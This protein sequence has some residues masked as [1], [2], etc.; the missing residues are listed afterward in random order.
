MK[1]VI[2][3]QA[4]MSSTRLPGKVLMDLGGRPMLSQQLRRLGRCQRFDEIVVATTVN[5]T[6]DPIVAMAESEGVRWFR[7]SEQDVLSRYIG[8]AREAKADIVV[9]VTA[10]CPLIDP[11]ETDK[12]IREIELHPG[13]CDYAANVVHR[14]YP[15]GLDTEAMFCDALE[16]IGRLGRSLEAQ[17]HVTHFLRKERSDLF[18]VRSVTDSE[19]NSHLRWTV[20]TPEDMVMVRRLC[21]T[22]ALGDRYLGYREMLAQ[23]R[24]HPELSAVNAGV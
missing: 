13:E 21:E 24:A 8:A 2:I 20:D 5:H 3:V 11:E 17:E 7:G 23:I 10:D 14:T 6:D 4:R 15:Q 18:L 1:R 12:V 19:D 16:R 22:L 9:R